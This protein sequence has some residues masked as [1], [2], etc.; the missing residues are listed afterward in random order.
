MS[1]IIIAV[2][3]SGVLSVIVSGVF[4]LISKKMDDKKE[5]NDETQ[6]QLASM[7]VALQEIMLD[8]IKHVGGQYILKGYARLS[9]IE[10][11]QRMH[12]AYKNLGGNG[13][14]DEVMSKVKALPVK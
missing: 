11:L 9:E 8:R 14:A 10:D 5:K 12:T 1:E 6:A 13:F 3:G 7:S 2:I 4:Q